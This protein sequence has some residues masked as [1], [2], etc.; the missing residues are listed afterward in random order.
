MFES[1]NPTVHYQKSSDG[2]WQCDW[3]EG[4]LHYGA[5]GQSRQDALENALYFKAQGQVT[6][7]EHWPQLLLEK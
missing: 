7:I 2:F 5:R 4:N 6:E 3:W 1:A